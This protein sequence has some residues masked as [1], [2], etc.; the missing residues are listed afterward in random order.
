M[1]PESN[2]PLGLLPNDE[3]DQRLADCVHP[4]NWQNP[5]PQDRYDLVI[6]GGGPAGLVAAASAAG[7]GARTALIERNL[8]G[9]DCLNVGCVPSKA[10]RCGR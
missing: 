10:R 7:I 3:S 4:A 8:L 6:I 2:H 9:G 5:T 1:N